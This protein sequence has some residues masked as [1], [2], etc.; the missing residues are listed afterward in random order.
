VDLP[1]PEAAVQRR[2]RLGGKFV[3]LSITVR[4][5]APEIVHSV[6]RELKKDPRV[7]MTF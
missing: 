7:K 3:S 4:V 1:L 5:R 2:P 6:C